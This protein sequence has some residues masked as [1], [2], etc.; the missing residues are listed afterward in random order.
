VDPSK[1]KT[2]GRV[3]RAIFLLN[4]PVP[5]TNGA[6]SVQIIIPKK[7]VGRFHGLFLFVQFF[8]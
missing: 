1:V 4:H 7:Q 6:A 2:V 3:V 8:V 5:N